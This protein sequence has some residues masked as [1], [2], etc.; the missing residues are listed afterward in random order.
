[1]AKFT[2][3]DVDKQVE[4]IRARHRT[5]PQVEGD[6]LTKFRDVTKKRKVGTGAEV[7]PITQQEVK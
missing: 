2:M 7:P 3:K 5:K 4:E 1:M 6:M